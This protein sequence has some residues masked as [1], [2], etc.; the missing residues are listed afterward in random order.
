MLFLGVFGILFNWPRLV[1]PQSTMEYSA[2]SSSVAA[3][4]TAKA[5]KAKGEAGEAQ[6][7]TAPS[8]SDLV[9]GA[10]DGLYNES[11]GLMGKGASLLGEA[12]G[13]IKESLNSVPA[14]PSNETATQPKAEAIQAAVSTA[15]KEEKKEAGEKTGPIVKVHLK[16]GDV[17]QGAPLERTNDYIKVDADGVP[18]TYFMEEIDKIDESSS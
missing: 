16:T 12:G 6:N 7:G 18:V 13:G 5:K 17:V 8:G 14:P 1:Q 4:A 15:S 2:L 11:A 3:A 10:A 9:T